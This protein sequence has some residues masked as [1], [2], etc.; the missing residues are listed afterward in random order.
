M[1]KMRLLSELCKIVL[2]SD[3]VKPSTQTDDDLNDFFRF[4]SSTVLESKIYGD[5]GMT[6]F[7]YLPLLLYEFS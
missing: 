6:L 4:P 7:F 2:Y 3:Q 5:D 1:F